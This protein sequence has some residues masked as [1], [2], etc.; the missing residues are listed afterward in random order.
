MQCP[1]RPPCPGC[2]RI[3]RPGIPSAALDALA[4]LAAEAGLPPPAAVEGPP[5]EWRHRARLAVRGRPSSPKV[6]IFQEGSHRIA[7][8][9][10]CLV[11]H[12]LV[13]AV[14]AAVR[15][16]VRR[17]GTPPYADGPHRGLLRYVQVVVERASDAAQVVLVANDVEPRALEPLAGALAATLGA[18][19]HSLW[20]NGNPERT[21]V[22]LGGRWHRWSGPEAVCETIGGARVF[23]PPGAFG[24]ANLPL[25][26]RLVAQV[27]AWV[28][29]GARIVELHAGVGAIGLGLVGRAAHATFNE[30]S[31]D[32]LAGLALGV[33]ALAHTLRARTRVLPGSAT[34]HLA[35]LDDA[36]VVICDPPRRGLEPALLARLVA[37]PPRRLALVSCN[38]DA[39]LVEARA[40][41][42][43]GRTALR[44][45]VPFALFPWTSHTET[46]AL[47]ERQ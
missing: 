4:T 37:E 36:D 16:A 2:P 46:V 9:P 44:A 23:Y 30:V 40:V 20:W 27:H 35:A 43:G 12:P 39:F 24:Q 45:V 10:H 42:A 34:D 28:P 38:L 14:A 15:D 6:G 22:I 8:I 11:H 17:T 1:H 41:C 5:T 26:D 3:G 7:D 29:D 32:G 13:N 33:G 31:A 47:F 18:R 21:N 25:A 19:L